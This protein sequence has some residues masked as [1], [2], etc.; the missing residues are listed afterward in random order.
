VRALGALGALV[1]L[2]ALVAVAAAAAAHASPSQAPAQNRI[3]LRLATAAP[4]GTLWAKAVDEYASHV[5]KG[6]E[7]AVRVKVYYGGTAGDEMEVMARMERGQLDGTISGGPICGDVM[8][9]VRVLHLVGLYES[10]QE[11]LDVARELSAVFA[12]EAHVRGYALVGVGSLGPVMLFTRQKVTDFAS[13][14]KLPVWSWEL[15]TVFNQ[16]A[17]VMGLNVVPSSLQAASKAYEDGRVDGFWSTPIAA[18]GFQWYSQTR[19]FM[20]LEGIYLSGCLLLR[21]SSL[22]GMSAEDR[23]VLR[24]AGAQLSSRLEV[25]GTRMARGLVD[26]VFAQ[27]GLER[28]PL[29]PAFLRDFRAAARE[30]RRSVSPRLVPKK[31]IEQAEQIL[32][33][34]RTRH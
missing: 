17:V 32:A 18:L 30:A 22:E 10:E 7:G 6:T 5:E 1:P 15:S 26:R 21:E 28:L 34:R 13:L 20:P 19:F 25:E 23:A 27:Q 4:K 9:S 12:D 29:G 16:M 2:A 11:M 31:L 24:E 3:T 14:R 8:P 33:R